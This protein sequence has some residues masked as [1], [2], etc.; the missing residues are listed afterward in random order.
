MSA[1]PVKLVYEDG[2]HITKYK[3]SVCGLQWWTE[4]KADWCCGLKTLSK[5]RL[6]DDKD[7]LS[8]VKLT[9]FK[10]KDIAC[11]LH[12]ESGCISICYVILENEKNDLMFVEPMGESAVFETQSAVS[13][14]QI[15][16]LLAEEEASKESE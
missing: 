9:G 7:F 8:L 14:E 1:I 10:I 3:C 13:E 5:V 2:N 11:Q 12:S 4:E 6:D 16:L 15:E